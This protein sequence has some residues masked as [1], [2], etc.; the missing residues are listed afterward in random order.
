MRVYYEDLKGIFRSARPK[1][2]KGFVDT[3]NAEGKRYGI[4][5]PLEVCHFIAQCAHESDYFKT[6]TEYA[7]GSAYEGRKD[8]GNTQRGD[9][10]RYKGRGVIQLTGRANYREMS[11]KLGIALIDWPEQ[12]ADPVIGTRIAMEYWKSRGLSRLANRNQLKQITRRING[13]YNGL[14]QRRRAFNV[15]WGLY[16]SPKKQRHSQASMALLGGGLSTVGTA[17]GIATEVT[18]ATDSMSQV[19]GWPLVIIGACLLIT[20]GALYWAWSEKRKNDFTFGYAELETDDAL[21]DE[22]FIQSFD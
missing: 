12:A 9:G 3:L 6:T 11:R 7:S 15:L 4:T 16:G 20:L 19:F 18:Y 13:G 17:A 22:R 1:I 21:D 14:R 2:L 5:T 10:R 8:L